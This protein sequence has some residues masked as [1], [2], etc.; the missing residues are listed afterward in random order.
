MK[1]KIRKNVF[2]SNS[3]SVHTLSISKDGLE[4]NKLK[5]DKNGYIHV[6]YGQFDKTHDI[7][8][9]QYEKLSYL[10][11]LCYYCTYGTC[12]TEDTSQ[13]NSIEEFI[14]DYTG[15]EGIIIDRITEPY[16][17]HQS[18]PYD[19]EITFINVYNRDSVINFVFNKYAA[20]ET[21]CD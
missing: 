15:C 3:S 20:L 17:D 2:D 7:Y 12:A 21:S 6:D 14:M 13:F 18:C 8:D 9:T 19:G 16:I 4:T 10:V 1:D 5:F 11:T